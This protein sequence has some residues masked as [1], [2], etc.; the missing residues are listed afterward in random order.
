M[1]ATVINLKYQFGDVYIGR[2]STWGNP[3]RIG[4]DGTREEVIEKYR[5]YILDR[6][7]TEEGLIDKLLKLDGKRLAC[8]CKPEPCH[9]DVL[10]EIIDYLRRAA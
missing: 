3:Y 6:L 9:G 7:M 2:G 4:P 8:Y 1:S 5:S 10:V